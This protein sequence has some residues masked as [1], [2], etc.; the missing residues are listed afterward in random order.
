MGSAAGLSDAIAVAADAVA[1]A[2]RAGAKQAEATYSVGDR[3]SAEARDRTITKIER[4]TSRS[5]RLRVFVD[6]GR[7]AT[8]ATTDFDGPRLER[9]IE[10]IVAQAAHVEP[11]EFAGLPAAEESAGGSSADLQLAFDDVLESDEQARLNE[12]LELESRVR[13]ADARISNS[14]GSHVDEAASSIALCNS[15]GFSG[16]YRSTQAG[17]SASPVAIDGANKRTGSY[18]TAARSMAELESVQTVAGLA[19]RRTVEMFGARKPGTGRTAVIFERDVAGSILADLF[20]AVNAANVAVGNSWLAN[21]MGMAIGSPLV[22]IVDDGRMPGRLGSSPFDGEGVATRRTPVFEKGV[23]TSFLYDSYYARK[24]GARSTG[25]SGS[26]GVQPNN[27]FL[28]PGATSLEALIA[29]TSRGVLVLDTIG[30][31]TEYAS[32]TYSRGARG[33]AIE[34]GELAYPIEQFTVAAS[35]A[36]MLAGIDAVASD[37]RFDGAI[38][39]P[40]FRVAEMTVSGS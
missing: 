11:D 25:N 16:A 36:E 33:F 12:A 31:A 2:M 17:R 39:S 6:G 3:F 20:A 21:R 10:R 26:G 29:D 9:A 18:A 19:A 15:V 13:Q 4:S 27:F 7:M 40:S 38:V 8:L 30:F 5:L 34:N 37:L 22:T 28:Q 32:G 35:F 24:L 1:S 23:L 14:N